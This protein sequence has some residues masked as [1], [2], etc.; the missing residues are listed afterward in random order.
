[1]RLIDCHTHTQYS[2]DSEADIVGMIEKA[3]NLGLAAYAV[4]DHCEC[5]AWFDKEYYAEKGTDL[6]LFDYFGYKNDFEAS[7]SAVTALKEE[8]GGFNLLCGI[9][10]GQPLADIEIAEKAVSDPRLDLVIGS[11]HQLPS[12]KDF[13]YINYYNMTTEEIDDLLLRYFTEIYNM[14]RWGKFDVLGH[15]TYCLRYMKIRNGITPDLKHV[16]ELIAESLRTLAEKGKG[17]EINTS[18]LRQGFGNCFPAL[19][20]VKLFKEL[21]GEIISVGSDAHKIR[22]LGSNISD[23][24]AIAQA[25]G[26]DTVCYFKERKPHFIKI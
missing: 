11:L 22:D 10:L 17:I 25:A 23:G 4:T 7:L 12:E 2:M 19:K 14:C 16:D 24:M 18:G 3:K 26:F 13:Y 5:S 8:Y 15:L 1:M 6:E 9:E 21:G 20:Y